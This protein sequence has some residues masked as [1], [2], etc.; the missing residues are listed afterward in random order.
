M[1]FG[2]LEIVLIVV[3]VGL[4]ALVGYRV[5][6]TNQTVS[7]AADIDTTVAKP[8][9]AAAARTA[10]QIKTS[11]DLDTASQTLDNTTIDDSTTNDIDEQLNF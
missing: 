8:H 5:L 10:P 3:I 11:S 4:I 1:G 6:M 7:Q 9:A 2:V